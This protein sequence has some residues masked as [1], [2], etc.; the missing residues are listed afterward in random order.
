VHPKKTLLFV[1]DNEQLRKTTSTLLNLHRYNV[2]EAEDGTAALKMMKQINPDLVICDVQMPGVNG[3]DVLDAFRADPEKSCTPF[4][5]LS[6]LAERDQVRNGL[7]RG[8]DDYLTKPFTTKELLAS[9]EGNL[10]KIGRRREKW[11][12]VVETLRNREVATLSHEVRT[13]LTGIVAGVDLMMWNNTQEPNNGDESVPSIVKD[14]TTRLHDTLS[15]YLLY[16]EMKSGTKPV[17]LEVK[18]KLATELPDFLKD[19]AESLAKKHNRATDLEI[20]STINYRTKQTELIRRIVVELLSNAF[21]F[22]DPG[23]KVRVRLLKRGSWDVINITDMGDGMTP[24][25]I[26]KIGPF[27]QFARKARE[28]QG[29]GI[30]L[31]IARDLALAS[32]GSLTITPNQPRGLSVDFIFGNPSL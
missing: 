22:S 4:I 1:E 2:I 10:Q 9:I 12:E 32:G 21:S 7:N 13:P 5:F 8:A 31:V 11:Q 30:G 18:D 29:L 20:D 16:L 25:E 26:I 6:G 3:M 17:L 15:R 24:E 23:T 27:V 19:I 14:S 28:Q